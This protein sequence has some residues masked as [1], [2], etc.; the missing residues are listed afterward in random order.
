MHFPNAN[1]GGII[2]IDFSGGRDKWVGI[3]KMSV[4]DTTLRDGIKIGGGCR[5]PNRLLGRSAELSDLTSDVIRL[6]RKYSA[7][8][9]SNPHRDEKAL[10]ANLKPPSNERGPKDSVS[11]TNAMARKSLQRT[12]SRQTQRAYPET[13]RARHAQTPVRKEDGAIR[14]KKQLYRKAICGPPKAVDRVKNQKR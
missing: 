3:I 11:R 9:K 2:V 13:H 7:S 8:G 5:N 1:G 10:G 12:P 6:R 4:G 14:K